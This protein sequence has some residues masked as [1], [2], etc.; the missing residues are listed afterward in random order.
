MQRPSQPGTVGGATDRVRCPVLWQPAKSSPSPAGHLC[1]SPAGL[2]EVRSIFSKYLGEALFSTSAFACMAGYCSDPKLCLVSPLCPSI[3]PPLGH[4]GTCVSRALGSRCEGRTGQLTLTA[5]PPPHPTL[6]RKGPLGPENERT[7]LSLPAERRLVLG[8][9]VWLGPAIDSL[10]LILC[11]QRY[12]VQG[13]ET[14]SPGRCELWTRTREAPTRSWQRTGARNCDTGWGGERAEREDEP[15][16]GGRLSCPSLS[17][18]AHPKGG[19][20]CVPKWFTGHFSAVFTAHFH[21]EEEI[22]LRFFLRV[23]DTLRPQGEARLGAGRQKQSISGHRNHIHVTNIQ[24]SKW[25]AH[26]P[27]A[28]ALGP[29]AGHEVGSG[30][31][32]AETEAPR[33]CQVTAA[34][35]AF[36]WS[37]CP[38][39][40]STEVKQIGRA[41]SGQQNWPALCPEGGKHGNQDRCGWKAMPAKSRKAS[42]V[43]CPFFR[44]PEIQ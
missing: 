16:E 41:E 17:P 35:P 38:G 39:R 4:R 12:G 18:T 28:P 11:S 13:R 25:P 9:A 14:P 3:L 15:W 40:N 37:M 6:G 44:V 42:G 1:R 22:Y 34:R 8:M 26:P 33:T 23:L 30:N 29:A 43:E 32:R 7:Q 20:K 21:L 10:A 36:I 2:L 27:R 5:P 19:L 31:S 24:K